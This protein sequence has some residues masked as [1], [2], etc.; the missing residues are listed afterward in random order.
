MPLPTGM[1]VVRE[2]LVTEQVKM[3]PLRINIGASL[4]GQWLGAHIVLQWAQDP[5]VQIPGADM[6]PHGKP[7]CGRHPTY[8]KVEEDGHGC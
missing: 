3:N 1:E 2:I 5:P 8:K 7:C 4:V 6:A